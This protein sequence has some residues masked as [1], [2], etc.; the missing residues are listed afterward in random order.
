MIINKP[1]CFK[2]KLLEKL[3]LIQEI[4]DSLE[5]GWEKE[6]M[7]G[8]LRGWIWKSEALESAKKERK[9]ASH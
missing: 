2:L 9:N 1:D 5:G 4:L 3:K 6:N 7:L 8:F